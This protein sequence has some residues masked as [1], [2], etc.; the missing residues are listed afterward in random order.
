MSSFRCCQDDREDT[1]ADW[2]RASQP[3][4]RIRSSAMLIWG[5]ISGHM[6]TGLMQYTIL[7]YT[8]I[9]YIFLDI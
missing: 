6:D 2:A 4:H 7:L 3:R 1:R 8:H 9:V 5:L